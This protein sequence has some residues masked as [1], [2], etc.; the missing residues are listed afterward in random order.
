[1]TKLYCCTTDVVTRNLGKTDAVRYP[2]ARKHLLQ[3]MA[4]DQ[5]ERISP[6]FYSNDRGVIAAVMKRDQKRASEMLRILKA[7]KSPS[8]RNI[9]LDGSRAV[10]LIALH[11]PDYKDA[12]RVV[13]Y[14]MKLLFY[15]RRDQVFYPGIPYLVDRMM[16]YKDLLNHNTKQ[17]YGT[18]RWARTLSDGSIESGMFPIIDSKNLTKRRNKFDLA[19]PGNHLPACSHTRS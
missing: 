7:I 2:V 10:W 1:M 16:V 8:A 19:G 15:R 6:S 3:L 12:A 17:L 5:A 11:N 4:D 14:K 9:G 13:L 18:Q